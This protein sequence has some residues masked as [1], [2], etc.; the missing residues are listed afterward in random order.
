MSNKMLEML[1]KVT[2]VDVD[3]FQSY[4]IDEKQTT[5]TDIDQYKLLNVKNNPIDNRQ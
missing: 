1:E 3:A 4:T 2:K 5:G